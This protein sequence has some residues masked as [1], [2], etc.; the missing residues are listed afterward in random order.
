MRWLPPKEV[1]TPEVELSGM[2]SWPCDY[3][4]GSRSTETKVFS[5]VRKPHDSLGDLTP[6][7]HPP[8]SRW[9]FNLRDV[10]QSGRFTLCLTL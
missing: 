5:I 2:F 8:T 3:M 9:K 10:Y 6:T 7:E 4:K 1:A